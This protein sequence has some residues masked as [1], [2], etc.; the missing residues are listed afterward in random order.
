MSPSTISSSMNTS[1]NSSGWSSG[2]ISPPLHNKS[3]DKSASGTPATPASAGS[4]EVGG[5]SSRKSSK[6]EGR[7]SS[8]IAR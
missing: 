6:I 8:D 4:K 7:R 2:G 5:D 1:S 3:S